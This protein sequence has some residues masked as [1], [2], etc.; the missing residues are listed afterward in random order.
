[1]SPR[2]NLKRAAPQDTVTD[3][4]NAAPSK[5]TK[6]SRKPVVKREKATTDVTPVKSQLVPRGAR[7][8]AK[9]GEKDESLLRMLCDDSVTGV[10]RELHFRNIPHS[11]I[12]WS[13]A[14]H[15][16]KINNWRNRKFVLPTVGNKRSS[17]AYPSIATTQYLNQTLD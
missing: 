6:T 16:T 2:S 15:V 9:V 8:T 10:A 7:R 11:T 5:K 13:D 17:L 14:E 12:D 1:M 3:A 4:L